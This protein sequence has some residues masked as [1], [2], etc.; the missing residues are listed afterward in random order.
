MSL[1]RKPVVNYLINAPSAGPAID[2]TASGFHPETS[3][4][5]TAESAE[6]MGH[7]AGYDTP[8]ARSSQ[9]PQSRA[10][11]ALPATTTQK[12]PSNDGFDEMEC[13]YGAFPT[14]NLDRDD[15]FRIDGH[16]LG[17]EFLVAIIGVRPIF[18]WKDRESADDSVGRLAWSYYNLTSTREENLR[19]LIRLWQDEGFHPSS[20]KY[21][22]VLAEI[23]DGAWSGQ[24]VILSISPQSVLRLFAYRDTLQLQ[25]HLQIPQVI[26]RVF[27]GEPI[28]S[29][30]ISFRPWAFE[31]IR[32]V[33]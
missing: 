16:K 12:A 7:A 24:L 15:I 28:K 21:A 30:G 19:V 33:E 8:L 5:L 31:F 13:G 9:T 18:L 17:T 26:T 22:E 11:T 23:M 2:I 3:Q 25:R 32:E 6:P 1:L 20:R 4:T 14:V 10:L 27:V 29:R